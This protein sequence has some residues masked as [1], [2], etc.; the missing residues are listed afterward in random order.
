M[1]LWCAAVFAGRCLV[2][3]RVCWFPNNFEWFEFPIRAA[4]SLIKWQRAL[5]R[6][7]ELAWK[8]VEVVTASRKL[9]RIAARLGQASSSGRS[10]R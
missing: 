6:A 10:R 3:P 5:V 1:P 4:I 2:L 9:N 7:S 8:L